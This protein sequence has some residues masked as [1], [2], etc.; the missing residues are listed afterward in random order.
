MNT[1]HLPQPDPVIACNWN[2]IPPENRDKH[3]IVGKHVFASVQEVKDLPDGYA[4]RLLPDSTMLINLAEYISND[5]LCC[6]FVR[7]SVDV[8]PDEG[9]FWLRLTGGEGVKAYIQTTMLEASLLNESVVKAA[10]LQ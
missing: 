10:G 9:P 8:E 7:F 6:R 3:M 4:F 5:R 2:A 1:T